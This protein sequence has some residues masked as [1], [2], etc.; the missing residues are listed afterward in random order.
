MITNS[1]HWFN[2]ALFS[3]KMKLQQAVLELQLTPAQVFLHS[4]LEQL[5]EKDTDHIFT[6]PVN[7]KEVRK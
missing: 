7:L 4:T 1:Q 5:Q 3:G 6:S 2:L